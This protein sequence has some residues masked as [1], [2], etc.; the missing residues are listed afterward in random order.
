MVGRGVG[1]AAA[2]A[3]VAAA[4]V[5]GCAPGGGA[6][7][8]AA[9]PSAGGTGPPAGAA[10]PAATAPGAA[11]DGRVAAKGGTLGG[12]GSAC[13]LPVTFDLAAAWV[14][15]RIAPVDD[16]DLR[17]LLDQGTVTV[18][19]EV[20]AKPAGSVGFLR[21][22]TDGDR[23]ATPRR[24][25]ESFVAGA[26]SPASVVHRDV[27]LAADPA[28]PAAEVTYAV[29]SRLPDERKRVR[30]LAVVTASGPVVLE[31]GGMDSAEHEAMLP[32][33]ALAKGSLKAAR[34]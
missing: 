9:G 34:R 26:E 8:L 10:G 5:G 11:A 15:E 6:D 16:P 22:W 12:P 30:A 17:S 14:P 3:A 2:A 19:C 4:L 7:R 1:K 32:A 18:V 27:R 24:V 13:P 21:V 25:L 33:Y 23:A 29:T 28:L 20:D 31:L